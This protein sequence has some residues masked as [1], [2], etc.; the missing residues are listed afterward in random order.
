MMRI[1]QGFDAHAFRTA[2]R[3]V[4]GGVDI[5]HDRGLEA[6]SDGDVV[7]HALCDALLGAAALGDIG[8]HFPPGDPE[9]RGIDSRILLRRVT[10]LVAASGYRAVNADITIVAEAPRMA[11]YIDAMR[12]LWESV[13][14]RKMY[15]TGGIGASGGNEGFGGDYHLPN[16]S[17]YCET[18]AAIALALWN[19]RMFLLH[20]ESKFADVL[21]REGIGAIAF[22][23]LAQGLLTDKYLNG[24][25]DGSR[26]ALAEY[27]WL[28]ERVIDSDELN[29]FAC[30]GH[31]V[32][33]TSFAF[34]RL[35]AR[36]LAGVLAHELGHFLSLHHTTRVST[37]V[38]ATTRSGGCANS[39]D[40]PPR[41]RGP[42]I[43]TI[44]STCG[45]PATRPASR[46]GRSG[47]AATAA[48]ASSRRSSLRRS[49][50]LLS[51]DEASLNQR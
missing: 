5:P 4:L 31:L 35:T 23:P 3:L 39:R 17:A 34:R 29:A 28:K 30:G 12:R 9:Y 42:V 16:A 46:P 11:G 50:A 8:R 32:V 13:T 44:G 47:S 24:I 27:D 48:R 43:W 33:V 1:G 10:E 49:T 22:S 15:L 37:I 21:E 51:V 26:M 18:C 20:G 19:H 14:L 36:Q 40:S 7:L 6:H 38:R 2:G 41:C 25:P 45:S